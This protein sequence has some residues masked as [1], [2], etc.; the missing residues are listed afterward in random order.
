VFY[1]QCL[2][3]PIVPFADFNLFAS[4]V[5]PSGTISSTRP[6]TSDSIVVNVEAAAAIGRRE[7]GFVESLIPNPSKS[8][9]P[10]KSKYLKLAS[11]RVNTS[12]G[13]PIGYVS[14]FDDTPGSTSVAL[15]PTSSVTSSRLK[16]RSEIKAPRH[17]QFNYSISV[18]QV[19]GLRES[20]DHLSNSSA[21]DLSEDEETTANVEF[22]AKPLLLAEC[23]KLADDE[24][25]SEKSNEMVRTETLVKNAIA[26]V[27][28]SEFKN[29][30][31]QH[32]GGTLD[33]EE[34]TAL[35]EQA[36]HIPP[37]IPLSVTNPCANPAAS[38]AEKKADPDAP[39][40]CVVDS[41]ANRLRELLWGNQRVE[42]KADADAPAN[43]VVDSEINRARSE[44]LVGL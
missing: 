2:R 1:L 15:N 41:S 16:P 39:A 18:A 32:Y 9:V 30:S 40:N 22:V 3:E 43:C 31:E 38:I 37:S 11:V 17:K 33:K 24:K 25:N 20:Q 12:A 42:K 10:K 36:D 6:L 7:S 21:S 28:A 27:D 13:A 14:P 19:R 44:T 35:V 23:A 5:L 26:P 29:Y 8:N 4:I 34:K